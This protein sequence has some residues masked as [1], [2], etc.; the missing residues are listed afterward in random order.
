MVRPITRTDIAEALGAGLR[1][2]QA[3]PL[4]GLAFG[5]L[6]ALGGMM[7]LLS[8]SAL[9]MAYLA[10]PLAAGFALIGPFVAVGLYEIS[11]RREQGEPIRFGLV[12][13]AVRARSEVGWMAFV[14]LFLFIIWM[15]QVRLLM[16]LFFGLNASFTTLPQFLNAVLTTREGLTFLAIGNVIGAMLSLMLFSLTVVSFPLLLD[17]DV[18]FVTAMITSV[19]AVATSPGP[20][21]GW[22]FVIAVVL[23]ASAMP[24]FLGLVVTLPVLGHATWH[25]YRRIVVPA[26]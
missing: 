4:Y 13:K 19:R 10:Y 24:V 3:K 25:L 17:R 15:Y 7:I 21:I 9:E 6:Y 2:L 22:A 23:M 11:R 1:D 26:E 12:W 16:A 18:D 14:T 5:A 8:V 20:M